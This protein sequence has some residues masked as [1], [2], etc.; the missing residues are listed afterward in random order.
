LKYIPTTTTTCVDI[1]LGVDIMQTREPLPTTSY[2][3]AK[4]SL[5]DDDDIDIDDDVDDKQQPSQ[6]QEQ[7]QQQQ[8]N[9]QD[10]DQQ[11][12]QEES[13][14]THHSPPPTTSI[15]GKRNFQDFV[16]EVPFETPAATAFRLWKSFLQ[17]K[18]N[19]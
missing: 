19:E 2:S 11:P 5:P 7:P 3:I 17:Q 1:S 9:D 8:S 18:R 10:Q 14:N 6:E 15:L 12:Q 16:V 13:N 4:Q